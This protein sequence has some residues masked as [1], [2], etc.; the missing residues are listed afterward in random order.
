MREW[1]ECRNEFYTYLGP[2]RVTLETV[3]EIPDTIG[4]PGWS[5]RIE[6]VGF[7]EPLHTA[8]RTRC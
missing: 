3:D 7:P 1:H 5:W 2:L 8:K 4:K 6:K